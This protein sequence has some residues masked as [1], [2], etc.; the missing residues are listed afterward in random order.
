MVFALRQRCR[1]VRCNVDR[2]LWLLFVFCILFFCRVFLVF[3]L[4]SELIVCIFLCLFRSGRRICVTPT[5]K[6]LILLKSKSRSYF[7][8]TDFSFLLNVPFLF[9]TIFLSM[10]YLHKMIKIK[11]WQSADTIFLILSKLFFFV[12]SNF[13]RL[14][15]FIALS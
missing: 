15:C 14:F 11:V 3:S 8:Q 2:S 1:F 4:V 10:F 9:Y 13:D 7:C 6:F 12:C 5:S